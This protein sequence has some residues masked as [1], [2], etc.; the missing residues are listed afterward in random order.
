V[1]NSDQALVCQV[2][3]RAVALEAMSFTRKIEGALSAFGG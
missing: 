2:P 1:C 3:V